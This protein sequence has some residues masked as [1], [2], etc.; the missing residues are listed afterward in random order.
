MNPDS[1][2]SLLNAVR[3]MKPCLVWLSVS[4]L[5]DRGQFL[6]EYGTFFRSLEGTGV[7]IAV[8]GHG[9]TEAIRSAMPYTTYGDGLSHLAALARTLHK[10]P[11]RP[12]AGRP[13]EK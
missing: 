5:R 3:E 7:A 8:G 11:K 12:R 9:P 10:P 6:Q 1:F 2:A 13:S 4:F